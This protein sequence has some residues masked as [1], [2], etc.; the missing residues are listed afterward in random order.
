MMEEKDNLGIP[1]AESAEALL[2]QLLHLKRYER[3]DA[4]RM[5]R[6]RQNIM[7]CVREVNSRK[8][9]SLTSLME[10]NIPW[11]FAEPRY[12]IAALFIIFAALQFW[13]VSVQKEGSGQPGI[14]T[15]GSNIALTERNA[16]AYTNNTF[17]YP[18]MPVNLSMF[19]GQSRES[20]VKFV[21]RRVDPE[22]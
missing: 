6:N 5:V 11:F 1:S 9:L 15:G 8:R 19:S 14:Y 7:R 2:K 22:E 18:E 17:Y 4:A 16:G 12:G 13:G 10:G 21:G 3:P 20:S